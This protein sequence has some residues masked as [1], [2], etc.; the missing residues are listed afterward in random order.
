MGNHKAN[1]FWG[2][3]CYLNSGGDLRGKGEGQNMAWSGNI[4]SFTRAL[5][6]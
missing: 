1:G 3:A 4:Y 5:W 2:C 6:F